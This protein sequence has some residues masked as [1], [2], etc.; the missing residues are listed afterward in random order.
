M[1]LQD[2]LERKKRRDE[3]TDGTVQIKDSAGPT[4]EGAIGGDSTLDAYRNLEQTGQA[5]PTVVTE[6]M[7]ET[8]TA[9]EE[10]ASTGGTVGESA[11]TRSNPA[12]EPDAEQA[13]LD[14]L[15]LDYAQSTFGDVD[16]AA[17]EELMRAEQD[18]MMGSGLMNLRANAGEAGFGMSGAAA[19][20]E[21]TAR[22]DAA[23]RL[24]LDIFDVRNAEED[25][26]RAAIEGAMGIDIEK[27]RAARQDA[28]LKA[29]I[30]AMNQ[31]TDEGGGAALDMPT[32][33]AA[34]GT[35]NDEHQRNEANA[36][37]LDERYQAGDYTTVPEPPQGAQMIQ[38]LRDGT[39]WIDRNGNLYV[40]PNQGGG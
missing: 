30:E 16:T 15:F 20:M 19:A 21:N 33:D 29:Q 27:E 18:R 5:E 3:Q 11:P 26:R 31:M 12:M 13:D 40:V 34:P 35:A 10:M 14:D 4:P 22:A 6:S 39:L 9:P 36:Q 7:R 28:I 37:A 32:E 1:L 23:R 2:S 25:Q 8:G 24:G 38:T 17:Q